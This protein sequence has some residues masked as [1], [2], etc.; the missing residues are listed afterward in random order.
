MGSN[1]HHRRPTDVITAAE[2]EEKILTIS[3]SMEEALDVLDAFAER[4]AE[5]EVTYKVAY[6]KSSLGASG[7]SGSGREG[8]MTVDE[9]EATAILACEAQLRERLISEALYEVQR[10]KL[11]TLRS[12][13]DALRTISANIRAQT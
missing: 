13:L 8:R 2:V 5:A 4:S 10:E 9:R 11:R 6:A 1:N 7:R 12:Q 3:D